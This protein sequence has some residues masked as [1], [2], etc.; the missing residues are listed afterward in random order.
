GRDRHAADNGR[1]IAEEF[2]ETG[3][4]NG[5]CN[6]QE[7]GAGRKRR[8]S[9]KNVADDLWLHGNDDEIG[10]GDAVGRWLNRN[11]R[12]SCSFTQRVTWLNNDDVGLLHGTGRDPALENCMD[13]VDVYHDYALTG[14]LGS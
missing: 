11:A 3:D 1:A 6:A 8:V 2:G 10:G 13:H 14:Q 12:L 5:G 7:R 9:W 4:R